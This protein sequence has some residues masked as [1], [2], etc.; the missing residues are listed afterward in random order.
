MTPLAERKSNA[1]WSPHGLRQG[2]GG[3]LWTDVLTVQCW[4]VHKCMRSHRPPT[5]DLAGLLHRPGWSLFVLMTHLHMLHLENELCVISSLPVQPHPHL[6][7]LIARQAVEALVGRY[8]YCML[9]YISYLIDVAYP[10]DNLYN[11]YRKN[12]SIVSV[13]YEE[14][15]GIPFYCFMY[16]TYIYICSI[17]E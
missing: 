15:C 11:S 8:L 1:G 5:M 6:S 12:Y 10:V 17:T 3:N 2:S 16:N 9:H 7:K 14:L 4:Q 13:R